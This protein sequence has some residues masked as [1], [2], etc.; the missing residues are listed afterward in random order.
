GKEEHLHPPEPKEPHH[1][2]PTVDPND[3]SV[4]P[5]NPITLTIDER[6][7]VTAANQPTRNGR[8][9]VETTRWGLIQRPD[10]VSVLYQVGAETPLRITSRVAATIISQPHDALFL[11]G[12]NGQEQ[13]I[14]INATQDRNVANTI[15]SNI[16]RGIFYVHERAFG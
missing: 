13:R 2:P 6:D 4:W 9:I 1:P 3:P 10:Y 16:L 12:T 15:A 14:G 7:G 11:V 5:T 8:L